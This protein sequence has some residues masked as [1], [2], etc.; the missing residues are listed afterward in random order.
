MNEQEQPSTTDSRSIPIDGPEEQQEEPQPTVQIIL[1]QKEEQESQ[2]DEEHDEEEELVAANDEQEEMEIE[3]EQEQSDSESSL[4]YAI[5]FLFGDND[6]SMEP[7]SSKQVNE[8]TEEVWEHVS[9]ATTSDE[10]Q[11]QDDNETATKFLQLE[12]LGEQLAQ[13]SEKQASTIPRTKL[14]FE[15]DQDDAS[16]KSGE[17]TAISPDN[18][19]FLGLEDEVMRVMLQIDGIESNGD[20]SIRKERKALIR[21]AEALLAKMDEHKQH[22]WE[23]ISVG[24]SAGSTTSS[25][26]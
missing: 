6:E 18:R 14:Q 3:Q 7:S 17:V 15:H 11:E 21:K 24:S 20:K 26:L 10:E 8:T 22:E 4:G 16:I 19:Q 1:Q 2:S 23:R 13:L 5:E 12:M 25:S 9:D